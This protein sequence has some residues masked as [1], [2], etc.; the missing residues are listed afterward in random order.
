MFSQ[1]LKLGNL[2]QH[3]VLNFLVKY[4]TD[5]GSNKSIFANK[6][7]NSNKVL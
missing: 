1:Y 7:K 6:E 5:W 2:N 3:F 4:C